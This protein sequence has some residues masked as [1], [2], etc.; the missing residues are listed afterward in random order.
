MIKSTKPGQ[1][2]IS[3]YLYRHSSWLAVPLKFMHCINTLKNVYINKQDISSLL[4]AIV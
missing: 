2:I 4:D 3:E 1:N